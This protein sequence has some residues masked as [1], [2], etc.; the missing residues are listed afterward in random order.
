[1]GLA[2]L[3]VLVAAFTT[4]PQAAPAAS[5]ADDE[6]QVLNERL[7]ALATTPG[8]TAEQLA[9]VLAE[10]ADPEASAKS[11]GLQ[12][13]ANVLWRAVAVL[14]D[15]AP[16]QVLL[17]AGL[18]PTPSVVKK[19]VK[20]NPNVE[21]TRLLL[22]ANAIASVN[23]PK[24]VIKGNLLVEAAGANPS[25]AVLRFLLASGRYDV[26]AEGGG[27][28]PRT[29]FAAASA[30]NPNPEVLRTLIEAGATYDVD[31]KGSRTP[32]MAAMS[33]PN[34]EVARFLLEL[35]FDPNVTTRNGNT[36]YLVNAAWGLH[37][38]AFPLL[39]EYGADPNVAQ[40]GLDSLANIGGINKT[41]GMM[42]AAIDAGTRVRPIQGDGSTTL[43]WAVKN[44]SLDPLAT[45]LERGVD[46]NVGTPPVLVE[47][48]ILTS[49][50][51][52][53]GLLLDAGADPDRLIESS[54]LASAFRMLTPG[55][56]ALMGAAFNLTEEAAAVLQAFV[57]GGFDV[58]AANRSG[59]TALMMIAS[60]SVDLGD[61]T[62]PMLRVLID[63]GADATLRDNRGRT[64]RDIAESNPEL[65]DVD[66]EAAFAPPVSD[67]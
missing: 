5:G 31:A 9:A 35:G 54:E 14:T 64:A 62:V 46:P 3:V 26:N 1:M 58:D 38:G 23:D 47:C 55:S 41:E 24:L 52:M 49:R 36:A 61:Q 39:V 27:F 28:P 17:D 15:P 65:E 16:I 40:V 53:V 33:N 2:P 21:V 50:P 29:P 8:T 12:G 13:W 57:D 18:A 37:P 56:N 4:L 63:A 32:L 42:A 7:Y 30:T 25:P 44:D 11:V 51:E 22:D 45:L 48:G 6:Q 59:T 43:G 20:S 10:G 60:R 34:L 67:A 66:L 19:A